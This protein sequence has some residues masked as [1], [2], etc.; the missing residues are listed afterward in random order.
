MAVTDNQ[1]VFAF[2]N[3][4]TTSAQLIKICS[5]TQM[6]ISFP[7]YSNAVNECRNA[8]GIAVIEIVQDDHD[9]LEICTALKSE[10]DLIVVGIM[11][12]FYRDLVK[13]AEEAGFD[14]IFPKALLEQNLTTIID[15]VCHAD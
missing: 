8:S 15:R 6:E 10:T 14:L 12:R 11:S 4:A 5:R 3:D 7:E 9:Y 2:L 1:K 13:Q